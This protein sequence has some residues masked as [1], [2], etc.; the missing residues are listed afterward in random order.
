[1][2]IGIFKAESV[3]KVKDTQF[4]GTYEVKDEVSRTILNE[5]YVGLV[6]PK[7]GIKLTF[8]NI[9]DEK[10]TFTLGKY[11]ITGEFENAVD[12]YTE[13]SVNFCYKGHVYDVVVDANGQ[14][15]S[16]DEW[17]HL[18]EFEDGATPDAH[19]TKKSRGVKWELVDM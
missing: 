9:D 19:Y 6:P 2:V 8:K 11:F 14:L 1:M 15:L 16:M 18:G 10:V 5:K 7:N 3:R 17:Y 4:Y 12:E 13:F